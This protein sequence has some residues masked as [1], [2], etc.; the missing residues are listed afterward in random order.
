MTADKGFCD[1]ILERSEA[2]LGQPASTIRNNQNK[3]AML[4]RV[5][6]A[7]ASKLECESDVIILLNGVPFSAITGELSSKSDLH[8]LDT[9]TV[10]NAV[11]MTR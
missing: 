10:G 6:S 7:K 1:R 2:T 5:C 4:D 9:E 3:L 8:E 11:S